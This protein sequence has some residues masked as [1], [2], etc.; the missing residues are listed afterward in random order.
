M[1]PECLFVVEKR[2][3][4]TCTHAFMFAA[5]ALCKLLFMKLAIHGCGTRLHI[6][7]LKG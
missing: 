7:F 3:C 5:A 2:M 6:S 4:C 1:K